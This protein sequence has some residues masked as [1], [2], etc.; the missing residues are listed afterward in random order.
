MK[1]VYTITSTF[2][3]EYYSAGIRDFLRGL[4]GLGRE[5]PPICLSGTDNFISQLQNYPRL[6][7]Y[8]QSDI[9]LDDF[10]INSVRISS[11]NQT[12]RIF[13]IYYIFY[14]ISYHVSIPSSSFLSPNGAV[15]CRILPLNSEGPGSNIAENIKPEY[16]AVLLIPCRHVLEQYLNLGLDRIHPRPL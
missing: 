3:R 9:L 8:L 1:G 6:C 4:S 5:A 14:F 15:K 12:T 7:S 13:G 11:P 10:G 2:P 16:L